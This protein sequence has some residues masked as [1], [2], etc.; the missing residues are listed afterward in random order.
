METIK[1][2]LIKYKSFIFYAVFGVL[3]TVINIASYALCYKYLGIPNVPSNIIAWVLAV[4]FAFITNKLYVFDSKNMAMSTLIPEL[5]KFTAARLATG[6]IDLL[7]IKFLLCI[8]FCIF[9]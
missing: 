5:I 8:N 6:G 4:L 7:I 1:R 2:L 3:T 9:H